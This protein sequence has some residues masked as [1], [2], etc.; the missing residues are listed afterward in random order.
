MYS[1]YIGLFLYVKHKMESTGKKKALSQFWDIQVLD[2]SI[3]YH[4][5]AYYQTHK[6][7]PLNT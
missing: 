6:H 2:L 5:I 4:R 3:P 1:I 7:C